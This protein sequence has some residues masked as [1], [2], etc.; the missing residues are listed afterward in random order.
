VEPWLIVVII[1][2]SSVLFFVAQ[3]FGWIDL[4]NKSKTSGSHG[5]V[6]GMGDEVF[7]PTRHEAQLE[8]D[9]QTSL[10]APAPVAGDGDKDIYKGN[11]TI[12]LSERDSDAD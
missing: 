12:D 5:G 11:V 10:P 3:R 6:M 1:V 2:A 7:H 8:L 4:S 9:R